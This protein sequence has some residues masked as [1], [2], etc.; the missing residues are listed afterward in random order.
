MAETE[1]RTSTVGTCPTC[2]RTVFASVNDPS[3][4]RRR[5]QAKEVA[6]LV[7]DGIQMHTWLCEK[8]RGADWFCECP[9][10][11]KRAKATKQKALAI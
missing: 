9:K 5:D 2:N 4:E 8:V 3:P 10:T 6:K 1:E 7:R 11:P